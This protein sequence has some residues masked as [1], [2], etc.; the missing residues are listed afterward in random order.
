TVMQFASGRPYA[1]TLASACPVDEID[2]AC[3]EDGNILNNSAALQSTANSA[4]GIN[5]AGPSPFAGLNSFCGPWT[6]QIDLGL[7]RNFHLTERQ[8]LSLQVQAFN[9]LNH[10]NYYVQNGNGVNAVQYLPFGD[11]CG[12]P[13]NPQTNQTCYLVPNSGPNGFGTLQ[14]INSLNGPRVLQ[15]AVKWSF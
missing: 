7:S 4:L 8:A 2:T 11:T 13:D 6:Q 15:F 14:R 12:N 3:E 10:A 1:A 9:L 5:G